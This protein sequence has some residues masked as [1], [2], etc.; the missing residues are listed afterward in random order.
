MGTRVN[1]Y[2]LIIFHASCLLSNLFVL[3]V[4]FF[5]FHFSLFSSESIILILVLA[6][7]RTIVLTISCMKT[8][9]YK[10]F[11]G[12]WFGL[13]MVFYVLMAFTKIKSDVDFFWL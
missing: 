6:E 5:C 9:K 3:F 7:F 11:V 12:F 8:S 2:N 10:C 1:K 4:F 13:I